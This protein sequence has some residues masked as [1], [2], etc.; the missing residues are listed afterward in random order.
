MNGRIHARVEDGWIRV[1]YTGP[2]LAQVLI[3]TG[4]QEPLWQEAFINTVG[5]ERVAQV[6][7][8]FLSSPNA[9]V[10]L[11]VDGFSQL[12]GRLGGTVPAATERR[13]R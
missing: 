11:R 5:E 7:P 1:T 9:K 12:I 6:R 4:E 13:R 2:E 10:W 3:G 8:T